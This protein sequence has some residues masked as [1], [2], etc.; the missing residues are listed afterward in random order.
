MDESAEQWVTVAVGLNE[1]R[2]N[3]LALVLIA[4]GIPHQRQAGATGLELG[5]DPDRLLPSNLKGRPGLRSDD[6]VHP[7]VGG[8]P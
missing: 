5:R 8:V 3:E 6:D 4:R 7:V 1:V 2:A